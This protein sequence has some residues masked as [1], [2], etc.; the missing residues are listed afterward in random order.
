MNI[1]YQDL[2]ADAQ[3]EVWEEVR[4]FLVCAG[5]VPPRADEE[6]YV[7]YEDRVNQAV[8][9]YINRHNASFNYDLCQTSN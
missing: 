4:I 9:D 3:L 1:T 8:D 7:A 6:D 2:R 5:Y